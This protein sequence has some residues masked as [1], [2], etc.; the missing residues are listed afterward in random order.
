[1][2][3]DICMSHD[4]NLRGSWLEGFDRESACC[5]ARECY[6]ISETEKD[7]ET[8]IHIEVIEP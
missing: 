4:M 7:R 8:L 6:K 3:S 2:L 1:M 5:N